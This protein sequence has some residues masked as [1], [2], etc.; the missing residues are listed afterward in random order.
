M[1][2][3]SPF[4]I[5]KWTSY[6]VDEFP[7]E[8][9]LCFLGKVATVAWFI[10]KA[11]NNFIF[12]TGTLNPVEVMMRANEA[13]HEFLNLKN[14][15]QVLMDYPQTEVISTQWKAPDHG[16]YKFNCDVAVNPNGGKAKTAAVLRNWR[17]KMIEGSVGNAQIGSPLQGEL[18][19]IRQACGMASALN[20]LSVTIES[21]NKTAIKLSASEL[22]PPWEVMV[23]V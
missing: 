16:L 21:D 7:M 2:K 20:M 8:T 14:S 9:A 13:M 15:P 17:G 4:S 23:L 10:W 5:L 6:I 18:Y 19:A 3:E 1:G 11:R 12:N 22:D